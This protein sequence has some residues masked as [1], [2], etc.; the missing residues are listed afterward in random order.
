MRQPILKNIEFE[1]SLQLGDLV[2]YQ[3]GQIVSRTLVQNGAVG[4]TL[5]AFA[6]GEGISAHE[7]NSD[8]LVHVL[9]G[10][11]VLTVG[12]VR[13]E[14]RAGESL[15][16]PANVPHAVYA[17]GSFKMILTVVFPERA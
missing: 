3:D 14:V 8:A 5:F 15:V 9:D 4:I 1:K 11:A 7:S 6:S 13:H 2:A 12:G 16:M 17:A 10:S